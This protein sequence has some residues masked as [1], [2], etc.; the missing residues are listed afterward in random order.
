V[1]ERLII[2]GFDAVDGDL[3]M[4]WMREGKLPTLARLA[5]R[6]VVAPLQSHG[7]HMPESSWASLITGT[8]PGEHG[9]YNWRIVRPG[10]VD[11]ARMAA[12]G[13]VRPFWSVL[14]ERSPDPKPKAVVFDVPYSG[15]LEDDEVIEVGGWGLRV[16]RQGTSWPPG[17]FEEL[18][19]RHGNHPDW[20]NR[21]YDRSPFSERRYR[22]VLRGLTRTRTDLILDLLNRSEWSLAVVNYVEGHYAGH[23]YHHHLKSAKP[24][25]RRARFGAPEGLLDLYREV[26]RNLARIVEVAGPDANVMVVSTIGLRP[27]EVSKELVHNTM[28]SL[29]YQVPAG[30]GSS[31]RRRAAATRVATRIAP[32][33]LRHRLRRLIPVGTAERIADRAWGKSIDWSRSRAVS[34]AEPGSSWIRVN[35]E[36]REPHGIVSAA[37]RPALLAEITADLEALIGLDTGE[38]AVAEVIPIGAIAPGSRLD[39]M[40]DLLVR[41]APGRRIRRV[42]HPRAGT[43]DDGGGPYARTEHNGRGFLVAAGPGIAAGERP[44]GVPAP[45]EF[46]IAPTA[47]HMFGCPV[48]AAMQGEVLGWLVADQR[49]PERA[50]VD[51]SAEP[52]F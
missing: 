8:T 14:R 43:I 51:I 5:E 42:R 37:E 25:R 24:P 47:L 40:P 36:G 28:V 3:A 35:L 15:G 50:D 22:R 7:E 11:Q 9:I 52:A 16:T 46:D 48:P 29:G 4:R 39:Q 23:A 2:V 1:T 21:D 44:E 10:T 18:R 19:S 34:E 26:D 32:R 30:P 17:L 49:E 45:R 20:I 31:D 12:G 27:N 41:W 6:G 33:F 38:P 13:W